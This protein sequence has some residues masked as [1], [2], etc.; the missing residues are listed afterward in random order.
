MQLLPAIYAHAL[1]PNSQHIFDYLLHHSQKPFSTITITYTP[2][3]VIAY[4]MIF[5]DNPT[6]THNAI[7]NLTR[8]TNGHVTNYRPTCQVLI[9]EK[10]TITAGP[11]RFRVTLSDGVHLVKDV[12]A[13]KSN[14]I[15]TKL[16]SYDIV[17]ITD[18]DSLCNNKHIIIIIQDLFVK[19]PDILKVTGE[20]IPFLLG[21][22]AFTPNNVSV[23]MLDQPS[24]P[25]TGT[26]CDE[27]HIIIDDWVILTNGSVQGAVRNHPLYSN[28]SSIVTSTAACGEFPLDPTFCERAGFIFVL[29]M[30]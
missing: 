14:W 25:P 22:E 30:N 3:I 15:G 7:S 13:F 5:E 20:P 28:G 2:V 9:I 16:C 10:V 19:Q 4:I 27:E 18:Y 17:E 8:P 12:L 29:K 26:S 6:L 24:P 1:F 11:T 23:S 21:L